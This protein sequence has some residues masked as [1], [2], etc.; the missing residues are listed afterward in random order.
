MTGK[1]G[2]AQWNIIVAILATAS[3]IMLLLPTQP[4][5][6]RS[7]SDAELMDTWGGLPCTHRKESTACDL[8]WASIFTE[9]MCNGGPCATCTGEEDKSR[10]VGGN[11]TRG[12][13]DVETGGCGN[14]NTIGSTQ[15]DL[16]AEVCECVGGEP[17]SGSCDR[18]FC[19]TTACGE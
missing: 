13:N 9:S 16:E 15:W 1:S 11:T 2:M 12:T 6:M 14:H 10:C 7:V 8:G 3:T 4:G 19:V 5:R 18:D 17:T